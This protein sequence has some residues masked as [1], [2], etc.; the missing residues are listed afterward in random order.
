MAKKRKRKAEKTPDSGQKGDPPIDSAKRLRCKID[1]T[2]LPRERLERMLEAGVD[3]L[4]CYRVLGKAKS[5]VVAEVLRGQGTFYEWT[6]YPKG[7]IYDQ[8]THSQYF[9][10]AHPTEL[11]AGE[12]GHFH[13][14]LRVKG[15]PSGIEPVPYEGEAEWPSG[16]KA[17]SHL[18][19]ISMNPQGFP[20]RIFTANRWVTGEAWYRAEDVRRM[21]EGFLIDH[22]HPSWPANRWISGMLRLF[23]P[24]IDALIEERDAAITSWEDLSPDKDVFEDRGLEITSFE[25]ISVEDRVRELCALLDESLDERHA[26][27]I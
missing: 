11:R 8:D 15:F 13:S 23:K 6:H 27:Q 20:I 12:H 9:Y 10:H 16:D 1:L 19:G 21:V 4:E 2:A 22:A 25:D 7:D 26:A 3:I 5:N 14:F 24:E 18:I 17:L